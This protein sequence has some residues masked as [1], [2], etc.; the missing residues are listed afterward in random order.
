MGARAGHSCRLGV[1]W[2]QHEGRVDC[3]IR[4]G[5]AAEVGLCRVQ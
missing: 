3:G 2:G 5:A 1:G 4:D